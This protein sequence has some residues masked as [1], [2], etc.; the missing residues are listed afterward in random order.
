[1]FDPMGMATAR[2][3]R[4]T[5][6]AGA[7][8]E[9]TPASSGTPGLDWYL[10]KFCLIARQGKGKRKLARRYN[11]HLVSREFFADYG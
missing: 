11:G 7:A 1:M 8:W 4:P 2:L 10:V 9:W 6:F 3:Y 5:W